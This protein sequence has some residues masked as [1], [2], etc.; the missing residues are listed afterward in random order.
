MKAK[1]ILND[2]LNGI[3]ISF[4]EKPGDLVRTELKKAG[5]RWHKV[6]KVWYAKTTPERLKLAETLTDNT[7]EIV[8]RE[9]A[10]VKEEAARL[11]VEKLNQIKEGYT[12]KATGEGIYSGWTGC[13]NSNLFG[14][15]LKKAILAELKK[16][17]IKATARQ[18]RGGYTDSFTFTITIPEQ[19]RV[20][21]EEYIK[22]MFNNHPDN[23]FWWLNPDGGDIHRDAFYGLDGDEQERVRIFN[24]KQDYER[25]LMNGDNI[26]AKQEFVD[27][28]KAIIRSFNSDHSDSQTDYFDRGFYDWYIW[29]IA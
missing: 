17:G 11:T 12:F 18:R 28:V 8:I 3:E 4:D 7:A 24:Y 25:A 15:E 9:E 22:E 21:E 2:A 16:N 13:N 14:T 1:Y 27:T 26:L 19:F 29:K 5:Y 23:R 10:E 20:T 6:K